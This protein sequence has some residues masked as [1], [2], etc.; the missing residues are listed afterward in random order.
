MGRKVIV[1]GAGFSGLSA[2]AYL[3]RQGFQVE[4]IEKNST[5]GG[6]ARKLETN[7]FSFDMGPS[8]YWMPEVFERFFAHFDTH[9]SNYYDLVSIDPSIR[10]FCKNEEFIDFPSNLEEL[11]QV[12]EKIESG[13]SKKLKSFL[14]DSKKKYKLGMHHLIYKPGLSYSEY[15]S[16]KIIFGLLFSHSVGSFSAYTKGLFKDQRIRRMLDSQLISVGMVPSCTPAFYSLINYANIEFGTWYPMGG[17]Q[18]VAESMAEVCTDFGVDITYNVN[19]D[20]LDVLK[21]EVNSAHFGFRNFYGEYFVSS[22][23]YPHTDSNLLTLKHSNY[24]QKYW[25]KKS[26]SPS[27]LTFYIGINKKVPHLMHHNLFIG[28]DFSNHLNDLMSKSKWSETP[29]FFVTAASKT[30]A[31]VAPEGCECLVINIPVASG[32]DD[33]GKIREH[34]FNMVIQ[35]LEHFTGTT[36]SD[37]I[38]YHKSY[39]HTDFANDYNAY[40]GNAYGLANILKQTGPRRPKIY[41]KKLSNL[42]YTGHFTVPGAG[43]AP[44]IIS[45]EIVAREI[46]KNSGGRKS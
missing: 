20:Q 41:S 24:N 14:K 6:R 15:L 42:F 38:V 30:D 27:T 18:K 33:S 35:R 26:I 22:A 23:D 40:K 36:L 5:P 46:Y 29:A 31:S 34:Y 28:T 7:G 44:S 8:K 2:A 1:L 25:D 13:S 32:L 3:S 17:M 45:G 10:I 11:Y 21:G 37:S 16:P 43:V 12:F 19:V 39:A 9:P 4:I